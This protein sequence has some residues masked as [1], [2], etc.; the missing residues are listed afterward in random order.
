[1]V[2]ASDYAAWNP[3]NYV[4]LNTR[5][6]Q[7]LPCS[8][9]LRYG[10][11]PLDTVDPSDPFTAGNRPWSLDTYLTGYPYPEHAGQGQLTQLDYILGDFEVNDPKYTTHFLTAQDIEDE[12]DAIIAK[13]RGTANPRIKNAWLGNYPYSASYPEMARPLPSD[14]DGYEGSQYYLH[15]GLNISEPSCYPRTWAVT[16]HTSAVAMYWPT[17][18][19]N[20]RSA[21]FWLPLES[22]SGAARAL[23][24]G[25]KL[26]PW[27]NVFEKSPGHD[28]PVPERSD[29]L[30][31]IEHYRMRGATGIGRLDVYDPQ[32]VVVELDANGNP[33]LDANGN[34]IPVV[35]LTPLGVPS[36][37]WLLSYTSDQHRNDIIRAWYS[38]GDYFGDQVTSFLNLSTTKTTGLEWSGVRYG[39][40]VQTLVSNLGSTSQAATYPSIGWGDLP[41]SSASVPANTHQEFN[42]TITNLLANSTLDTN[43]AP[44]YLITPGAAWSSTGGVNNGP[45]IVLS[46]RQFAADYYAPGQCQT[47]ANAAM[48]FSFSARS[49][50]VGTQFRCGYYYYDANGTN[51]G[52]ATAGAQVLSTGMSSYEFHFTVPNDSRIRS[53][54]PILYN[55]SYPTNSSAVIYL[56]NLVLNFQDDFNLFSNSTFHTGTMAPW[57]GPRGSWSPSGGL[58][59]GPCLKL[60]NTADSYTYGVYYYNPGQCATYPNAPWSLRSSPGRRPREARSAMVI[61]IWIPTGP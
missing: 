56:D 3:T 55:D 8:I 20:A 14:D 26:I 38:L 53:I 22:L 15:S 24:A 40:H 60:V 43:A 32:Q 6:S 9:M 51:L 25:H 37:S 33:I 13:V 59:D 61:T 31:T 23:P 1:M 57:A 5:A 45:C 54:A 17:V 18:S 7:G 49:N 42:Y 16:Y 44:W 39:N 29:V 19:P 46:G 52:A 34:P 4:F 48:A 35:P 27:V 50:V 47:Q 10:T 12:M 41:A 30:A 11:G 36:G 2:F 28:G 58:G 21:M